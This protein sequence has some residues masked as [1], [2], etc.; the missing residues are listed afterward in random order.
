MKV[1]QLGTREPYSALCCK[2]PRPLMPKLSVSSSSLNHAENQTPA[3]P[4][5]TMVEV[6]SGGTRWNPTREQI[7]ILEMLY[8]GGMRTPN[9]HQIESI[10]AQLGKYGK[11]EGKNVFYWFQNH[12]AR[13]RQ[14]Q[15]RCSVGLSLSTGSPQRDSLTPD[16]GKK[17]RGSLAARPPFVDGDGRKQA[18]V[19]HC[20]T[21]RREY[22]SAVLQGPNPIFFDIK[23]HILAA[24]DRIIQHRIHVHSPGDYY[25]DAVTGEDK[26]LEEYSS[27]NKRKWRSWGDQILEIERRTFG[28]QKQDKTL[29]LFPLHPEAR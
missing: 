17:S 1:Q 23:E 21:C 15:K 7:G 14:R 25:S 16:S 26:K 27:Y 29:E 24:R 12:K 11:I 5:P 9:A 2:R 22:L 18:E 20:M 8:R 6:H 28:G 10:T 3:A 13:E 19:T 4:P